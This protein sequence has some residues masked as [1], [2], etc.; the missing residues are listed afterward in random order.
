MLFHFT[1]NCEKRIGKDYDLGRSIQ[2]RATVNIWHPNDRER[3][4]LYGIGGNDKR[5]VYMIIYRAVAKNREKHEIKSENKDK[6]I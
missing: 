1:L 2:E 5:L 3:P 6:Y 4:E